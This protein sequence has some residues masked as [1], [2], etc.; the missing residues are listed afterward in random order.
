MKLTEKEVNEIVAGERAYRMSKYFNG[1]NTMEPD[2][3]S[4]DDYVGMLEAWAGE[5]DR[6]VNGN[7]DTKNNT[8]GVMESIRKIAAWCHLAM[9][10]YGAKARQ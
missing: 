7:D 3:I 5:A 8:A 9:E 2:E 4:L 10:V 1:L 6:R